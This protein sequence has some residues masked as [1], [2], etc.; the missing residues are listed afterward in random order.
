MHY[1]FKNAHRVSRY[2]VFE[3]PAF[4]LFFFLQYLMGIM[5][6]KNKIKNHVRSL[7]FMHGKTVGCRLYWNWA[8]SGLCL[9]W[10]LIVLV[11]PAT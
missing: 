5:K 11:K 9:L 3:M 8:C 2:Y 7:L 4:A 10:A 6:L 1:I